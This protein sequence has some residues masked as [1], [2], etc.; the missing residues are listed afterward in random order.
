MSIYWS[1]NILMKKD[2]FS[3]GTLARRTV[4]VMGQFGFFPGYQQSGLVNIHFDSIERRSEEDVPIEEAL[5]IAAKEGRLIGDFW[6]DDEVAL[7]ISV[8]ANIVQMDGS[9]AFPVFLIIDIGAAGAD[10]FGEGEEAVKYS[11]IV[12]QI[13]KKLCVEFN[14]VYAYSTNDQ[15]D[16]EFYWLDKEWSLAEDVQNHQKPKFISWLNYFSAEYFDAIGE[17]VFLQAK[18]SLERVTPH[19]VIVSVFDHPWQAYGMK[20]VNYN[21]DTWLEL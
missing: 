16:E 11:N 19:G 20:I 8:D 9:P 1:Y 10:P 4:D 17:D 5:E 18:C 21:K 15:I 6:K 13:F 14:A 2:A 7:S 3:R 12:K